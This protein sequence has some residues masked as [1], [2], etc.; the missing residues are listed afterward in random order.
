MSTGVK[1]RNT[2]IIFIV[3]GFWHGANWTFIIWGAL[4]AFYFLPLLLTNNNRN[5]LGI[6]AQGKY[7]PTLREM[8]SMLITFGLIVFAWIF[9][10]AE[11]LTHAINFIAEIFSG[12]LF[13]IPRPPKGIKSI[14]TIMIIIIFVLIEWNGR[15]GKYAIEKT[16][17]IWNKSVR[18]SFYS[19]IATMV[20]LHSGSKQEFIYFQF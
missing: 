10:R 4:N 16:G 13:S 18:W 19:I 8:L 3:S 20:L 7:L 11:N 5:N 2:F 15:E 14:I 6:V 9:F 17:I 1:V 12:S